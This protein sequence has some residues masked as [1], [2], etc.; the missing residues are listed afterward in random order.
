MPI[1]RPLG[2]AIIYILD[3]SLN[4]LPIGVPGEL[5][6]G[7]SGLAR[8]YLNRPELTSER[9]IPEP[10][11]D[12]PEARLYKTEILHAGAATGTSSFWG[13]STSRSRSGASASS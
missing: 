8:G 2:N 4:P 5:H 13:A 11:S 10:F 6:V 12:A 7:G 9:F 3:G 1:G